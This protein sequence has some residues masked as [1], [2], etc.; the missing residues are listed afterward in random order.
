MANSKDENHRFYE[1]IKG[2]TL[3]SIAVREGISLESI[4]RLNHLHIDTIY[5]GQILSLAPP[6]RHFTTTAVNIV[7]N[8]PNQQSSSKLL[9]NICQ[10]KNIM[11]T[12]ETHNTPGVERRSSIKKKK[13]FSDLSGLAMSA[14]MQSGLKSKAPTSIDPLEGYTDEYESSPL[15]A[16]GVI[17]SELFKS[18]FGTVENP[19]V[20]MG[21]N[22]QSIS[23]SG[24]SVQSSLPPS[25]PSINLP[26]L[27]APSHIILPQVVNN[28]IPLLPTC[29]RMGSWQLL[30]SVLNNGTDISTFYRNVRRNKHCLIFVKTASGDIFGGFTS[31]NWKISQ[32]YC[33]YQY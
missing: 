14:I 6:R 20:V 28:M 26:T 4:R 30:Y 15:V 17:A 25:P 1:V 31:E 8:S 16:I 18:W 11:Q 10:D 19:E 32:T 27:L 29:D 7:N 9:D 24:S 5:P 23:P 22:N 33:K 12:H 21:S 3:V 2:D 13:S